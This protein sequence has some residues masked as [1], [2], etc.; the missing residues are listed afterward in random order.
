MTAARLECDRKWVWERAGDI[1][2]TLDPTQPWPWPLVCWPAS[3]PV[4]MMYLQH[5]LL[6]RNTGSARTNRSQDRLRAAVSKAVSPQVQLIGWWV[7]SSE[8]PS[9]PRFFWHLPG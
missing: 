9:K 2:S 7:L 6:T 3:H 1:L 4:F 5:R 8:L